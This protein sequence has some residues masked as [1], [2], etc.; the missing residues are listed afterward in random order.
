MLYGFVLLLYNLNERINE[1]WCQ[2]N[3]NVDQLTKVAR[4]HYLELHRYYLPSSS[5]RE[6]LKK[7]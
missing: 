5:S 7:N 4:Q 6:F 1:M 2:N 3:L